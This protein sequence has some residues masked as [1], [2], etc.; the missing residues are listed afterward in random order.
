M[1]LDGGQTLP[2]LHLSDGSTMI[3]NGLWITDHPEDSQL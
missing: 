2:L 1:G 3:L